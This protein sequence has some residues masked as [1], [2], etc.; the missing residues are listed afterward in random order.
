MYGVT[1]VQTYIYFERSS[2]ADKKLMKYLVSFILLSSY[3][4]GQQLST[5][6]VFFLWYD[7][8][9]VYQLWPRCDV[10]SSHPGR[11]LNTLRMAI[12]SNVAYTYM[13]TDFMNPF[14]LLKPTW[15]AF[16]TLES[17]TRL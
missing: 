9:W 7:T 12:V 1:T 16:L 8:F 5:H 10:T 14:A 11:I 13:V 6:Q 2:V 17:A 15:C 3:Y 4:Y